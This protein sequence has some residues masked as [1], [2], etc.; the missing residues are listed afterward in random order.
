MSQPPPPPPPMWAK[1]KS[2]S[3]KYG[4]SSI[5]YGNDNNN[6]NNKY[7]PMSTKS[8][9][10]SN[11]FIQAS[12]NS[13][14]SLKVT[15]ASSLSSSAWNVPIRKRKLDSNNYPPINKTSI[16]GP[17][18]EIDSDSDNSSSNYKHDDRMAKKA[19]K[20]TKKE[21][22]K[23]KKMK[24]KANKYGAFSSSEDDEDED[25]DYDKLSSEGKYGSISNSI[26]DRLNFGKNKKTSASGM[27]E[28]TAKD[29]GMLNSRAER[30]QKEQIALKDKGVKAGTMT[31]VAQLRA[32]N[33]NNNY[34]RHI[35]TNDN[36][37]NSSNS[38]NMNEI[39]ADELHKL[40][41]VGTCN[42]L[43]KDYFRLTQAPHPS[44]I[45]P[46]SI[47]QKALDALMNKWNIINESNNNN[48]NNNNTS[49]RNSNIT[50]T[51]N[52]IVTN[53]EKMMKERY[54]YFCS[55]FKALRQDLT[56][57]NIRNELTV[58][59]YENHA[60]VA[61]L[62]KDTNEYNQ[63]QTQLKQLYDEGIKGNEVEF[64]AYRILYNIYIQHYN[65]EYDGGSSG[66]IYLLQEIVKKPDIYNHQV[67]QHALSVREA[68]ANNNY[69]RLSK[70]YNDT[71]NL[72]RILFNLMNW[73]W[74]ALRSIIKCYKPS[75]SA[76]F[77][78]KELGF[79][80]SARGMKFLTASD[81]Q[82]IESESNSSSSSSSSSSSGGGGGGGGNVDSSS[83]N[84]NNNIDNSSKSPKSKDFKPT[85]LF[86]DCKTS[87][88]KEIHA[89]NDL[90]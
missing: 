79:T 13:S 68:V 78:M 74:E 31:S 76:D 53:Y 49:L 59:V 23:M 27:F 65:S 47:L 46:P 15:A 44:T 72:G 5:D 26:E 41:I 87:V 66:M 1:P 2:M 73:R 36:N 64:L 77:V 25:E 42:N 6:Y 89:G 54:I 67:I 88:V 51:T 38:N 82:F 11:N 32:N 29:K 52:T 63:C 50:N 90:M 9:T 21:S 58:Q 37:N 3:N 16:Y 60:R 24:K 14:G 40:R 70:L 28:L 43:E 22:K 45:R 10:N 17:A 4:P 61:L 7:G 75:V 18:S 33:N 80:K 85:G 8:T 71:P 35:T 20:K 56:V 57:Q 55:Q 19:R 48:C 62:C 84:N 30:F 39:S 69:H 12:I 83:N 86:I 34:Y 81:I